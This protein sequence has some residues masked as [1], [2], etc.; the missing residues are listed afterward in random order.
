MNGL[1]YDIY[2]FFRKNFVDLKDKFFELSD[3]GRMFKKLALKQRA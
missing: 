1:D 3:Y 2:N